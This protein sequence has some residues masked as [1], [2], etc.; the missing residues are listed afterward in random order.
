MFGLN[1]DKLGAGEYCASASI[2]ILKGVR[3][4]VVVRI[5]LAQMAAAAAIAGLC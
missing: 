2:A 4:T 3:A 1:A 5:W